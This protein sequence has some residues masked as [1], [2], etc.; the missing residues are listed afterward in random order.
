MILEIKDQDTFQ[1]LEV[2]SEE[3][4]VVKVRDDREVTWVGDSILQALF[5]VSVVAD[6]LDMYIPKISSEIEWMLFEG[7]NAKLLL[8]DHRRKEFFSNY[9]RKRLSEMIRE[10]NVISIYTKI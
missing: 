4:I 1:T 3:G 7:G 10:K 8:L 9:V 2:L 5:E 6:D